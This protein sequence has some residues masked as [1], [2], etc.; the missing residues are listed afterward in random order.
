MDHIAQAEVP[1]KGHPFHDQHA[2]RLVELQSA[3]LLRRIDHHQPQL[4]AC[5]QFLDHQLEILGLDLLVDRQDF[6]SHEL[7][8]GFGNLFMF[9]GEILRGKHIPTD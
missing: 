5:L 8:G 7:L 9:V 2:G 4:G 1:G 3:V 6:A